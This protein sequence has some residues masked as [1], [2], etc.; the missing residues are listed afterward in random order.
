MTITIQVYDKSDHPT[1][2]PY[3]ILTIVLFVLLGIW[4][5]LNS[6]EPNSA[7][8]ILYLILP[9][10]MLTGLFRLLQVFK[11]Y[12]PVRDVM[13]LTISEDSISFSGEKINLYQIGKIIIRLW[14]PGVDY[15]H[16]GNNYF[17]ITTKY[18]EV[19][20]FGILIK[21]EKDILQIDQAVNFL[22]KKIQQVEYT[23][24]I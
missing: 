8:F 18:S 21:D 3:W 1:S 22:K 13:N 23:N 2:R 19:Y 15:L 5:L 17:E 14:K 11:D 6:L 9:I 16:I 7:N 4:Y 12:G 10:F 20:T 24:K